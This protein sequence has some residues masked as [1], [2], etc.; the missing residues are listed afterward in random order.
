MKVSLF[1]MYRSFGG[2]STSFTAYLYMCLK[3]AGYEPNI[4]RVTEN[5]DG[6]IRP[7]SGY[8]EVWYQNITTEDALKIINDTPSLLT[9]ACHP[10]HIP[11]NILAIPE[12]IGE[13]MRC[14]VH[15]PNEFKVYAHLEYVKRPIIIRPTMFEYFKDAVFIPHPYVTWFKEVPTADRPDIAVSIARVTFVK[16]TEIILEANRILPEGK[17]IIL[18]GAENRLYTRHKLS[19]LYPEY[20]QGLTGYPLVW[21]AG[22]EECA[23]AKCAVDMTYFPNDGG[24][25]QYSFM[26]AWDAG[27]V[28][29]LNLDWLRYDGEMKDGVNCIAVDSPEMLASVILNP[30]DLER[31]I[32][33]GRHQLDTVHDPIRIADQYAHELGVSK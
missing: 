10:K 24:G 20:E 13:G 19:K 5:G 30:P 14:V 12:M 7:F 31:Y 4:Y 17:K 25:T 22:P 9:A 11:F 15:D 21:G 1:F 32:S 2:G 26:E 28:N 8:N 33:N 27:T 18:R 29:I 3:F 23:R 6:R 16:R